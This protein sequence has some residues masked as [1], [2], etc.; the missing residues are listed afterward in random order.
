MRLVETHGR[1]SLNEIS[2]YR[3][4]DVQAGRPSFYSAPPELGV[5]A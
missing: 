3:V 5:I 4:A 2:G 1:A